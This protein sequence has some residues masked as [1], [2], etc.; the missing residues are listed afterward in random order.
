MN[1]VTG[2]SSVGGVVGIGFSNASW[3][4]SML[5]GCKNEGAVNAT[6]GTFYG[7]IV[8]GDWGVSIS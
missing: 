3:S 8:G 1:G 7:P 2:G 5:S 6:K 4:K